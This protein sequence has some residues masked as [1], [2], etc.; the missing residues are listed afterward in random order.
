MVDTYQ[1]CY[2]SLQFYEKKKILSKYDIAKI[3]SFHEVSYIFYFT[4]KLISN[5]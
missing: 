1:V 5:R 3:I 4:L 2:T